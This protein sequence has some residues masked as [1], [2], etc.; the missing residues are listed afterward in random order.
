MFLNKF[1][2]F[3]YRIFLFHNDNHRESECKFVLKSF[4][5]HAN[6]IT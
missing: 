6:M 4:M 1:I 3:V 5:T 2:I